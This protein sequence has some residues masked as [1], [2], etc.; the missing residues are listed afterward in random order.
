[1]VRVSGLGDCHYRIPR[2]ILGRNYGFTCLLGQ[3]LVGCL[4]F[5]QNKIM[6]IFI[7]GHPSRD[8]LG[9]HVMAPELRKYQI[10]I[11]RKILGR[12]SGLT[13]VLAQKSKN[14]FFVT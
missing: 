7:F 5:I 3:K 10:R 13:F 2:K 12:N 9:G 6:N 14:R 11:P 8:S 1:M 4:A